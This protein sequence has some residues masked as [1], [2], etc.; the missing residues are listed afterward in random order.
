MTGTRT[1]YTD[2]DFIDKLSALYRILSAP[3]GA[4]A[5]L[6]E[7]ASLQAEIPQLLAHFISEIGQARSGSKELDQAQADL[8][9][10]L[11]AEDKGATRLVKMLDYFPEHRAAIMQFILSTTIH[12]ENTGLAGNPVYQKEVVAYLLSHPDIINDVVKHA[13]GPIL[14]LPRIIS[15]LANDLKEE[16]SLYLQ[17]H[18]EILNNFYETCRVNPDL[19]CGL[20]LSLQ[21]GLMHYYLANSAENLKYVC[22]FN[23]FYPSSILGNLISQFP[24]HLIKEFVNS[25][26][27]NQDTLRHF[28][29]SVDDVKFI[30]KSLPDYFAMMIIHSILH[31]GEKI[32]GKQIGMMEFMR[33]RI[34]FYY[35]KSNQGI[36][37]PDREIRFDEMNGFALGNEFPDNATVRESFIKLIFS[38]PALFKKYF[39]KNIPY[40]NA[41]K[42]FARVCLFLCDRKTSLN[43]IESSSLSP[44]V[45][46]KLQDVTRERTLREPLN[47]MPDIYI[48]T[49]EECLTLSSEEAL[50]RITRTRDKITSMAVDIFR[51]HRQLQD[52][53]PLTLATEI[54]TAM[55][56][57]RRDLFTEAEIRQICL[58]FVEA[59]P[60]TATPSRGGMY[61]EGRAP[62]LPAIPVSGEGSRPEAPCCESDEEGEQVQRKIGNAP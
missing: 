35:I 25:L 13:G 62:V 61:T 54:A 1:T 18:P 52:E 37:L 48:D 2:K 41:L 44:T 43:D 30:V 38:D 14:S 23:L 40:W 22:M 55:V 9:K 26:I 32:F 19:I 56:E 24:A 33:G 15:T 28:C 59:S 34:M 49:I 3:S 42:E 20:P 57:T 60:V 46:C 5:D 12:D 6:P 36:N 47:N 4:Q 45:L 8:M 16:I 53:L 11:F 10:K 39:L 7:V 50:E 51:H 21:E 27:R 31:Q 58:G 29:K 17:S